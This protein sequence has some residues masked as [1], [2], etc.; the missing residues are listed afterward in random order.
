MGKTI[1]TEDTNPIHIEWK[2]Y[3]T[4]HGVYPYINA[5][6]RKKIVEIRTTF[7]TGEYGNK[8]EIL[9]LQYNIYAQLILIY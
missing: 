8:E 2:Y 7:H 4:N 6:D 9:L 3:K 1:N 5:L